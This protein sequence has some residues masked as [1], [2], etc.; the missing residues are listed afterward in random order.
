MGGLITRRRYA[1]LAGATALSA[2]AG[3][4]GGEN[5]PDESDLEFNDTGDDDGDDETDDSSSPDEGTSRG[6]GTW[7]TFR[8][9]PARTGVRT[10]DSG[11][12]DSLSTAWEM[13]TENLVAELEGAEA[14]EGSL[15][16]VTNSI[17]WP[18]LTTEHAIWI[19]GYQWTDPDA[20]D[21]LNSLR[22]IAVNKTEG[23]IAWTREIGDDS[24]TAQEFW[25]AP[26]LDGER[27][28]VPTPTEDGI[29]LAIHDPATGDVT[30]RLELQLSVT[31]SQPTVVDGTVYVRD[32]GSDEARLRAFDAETG[33]PLW[34][35]ESPYAT[36]SRPELTVT[37]E[38]VQ[39][40]ART[41]SDTREFVARERSDGSVRWRRQ[42]DLPTSVVSQ[43]PTVLAPPAVVDGSAYAAGSLQTLYQRDISP[44]VSFDPEAGEESWQY[45]P[46][47]IDGENNPAV[48]PDTSQ[49]VIEQLP[50]FFAVYG[51]PVLVDGLVVGTGY[52]DPETGTSEQVSYVFAVDAADGRLAWALPIETPSFAPVAAGQTIYVPTEDEVVALS[53]SGERTDSISVDPIAVEQPPAIGGGMLFVPTL[54]GLVALE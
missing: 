37:D 17:S 13:R 48:G 11:P 42:I 24:G 4:T 41:D 20:D 45:R 29:D 28:Y 35:V 49:E 15:P 38:T 53:S 21:R 39:Y 46:P 34:T 23:T 40:F 22:V 7:S 36:P 9:D 27:L 25:Y 19:T 54:D 47:G 10:A 12:G 8:G 51:Y 52:G 33:E 3:C 32:G 6:D 2:F 18:I 26:E 30:G 5:D 1:V 43:R 16:T 31:S 50:P 44:L 14:D